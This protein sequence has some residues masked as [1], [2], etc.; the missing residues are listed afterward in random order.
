MSAAL[1]LELDP[2]PLVLF[3]PLGTGFRLH[4]NE[5]GEQKKT[6]FVSTIGSCIGRSA[7]DC[8]RVRFGSTFSIAGTFLGHPRRGIH[9][10]KGWRSI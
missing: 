6:P 1:P 7:S 2:H 9:R 3:R 10:S 8:H 4:R 5:S